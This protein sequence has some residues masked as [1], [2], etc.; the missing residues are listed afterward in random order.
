MRG[1]G[2]G[3]DS[4]VCACACACVVKPPFSVGEKTFSNL[5]CI[6]TLCRLIKTQVAGP[7]PQTCCSNRLRVGLGN[8]F[9]IS[10]QVRL[11]L[12]VQGHVLKTAFPRYLEVKHRRSWWQ[13]GSA[14]YS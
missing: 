2:G 7:H 10:S 13:I 11:Q 8:A 12:V 9:P 14:S 3:S 5:S 6:R 1:G 4:G